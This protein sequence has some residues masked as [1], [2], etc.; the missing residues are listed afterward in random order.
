MFAKRTT[1]QSD[2]YVLL[3]IVATLVAIGLIFVYSSSSVYASEQFGSAHYYL[4]KHSIGILVG[5]FAF[6]IAKFISLQFLYTYAPLLF[7]GSFLLTLATLIPK[8]GVTIHG[9]SRWLSLPGL[10]FQPSEILKVAF[11]LYVARLL[12]K[13][14]GKTFTFKKSYLPILTIMALTAAVLLKQPDFGLTITLCITALAMV[15]ISGLPLTYLAVTCI[16]FLPAGI[17][18]IYMFPYRLARIM[19]FLNPWNDPQGAGFQIIQSLIAIGSGSWIGSGIA[20]SKQKFFYLPMQ[21]T[22][23]IFSII[24]E[25][26]G[27]IGISIIILLYILFLYKGM[28]IAWQLRTPFALNMVLGCTILITLQTIINIFVAT[29]L[30]PTKGIGLPMISYGNTSLVCTL[31]MIGLIANA[32]DHGK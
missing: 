27:F 11:I 21:H 9:S 20:H 28:K 23:F 3:G 12:S 4:K 31:L 17:L 32:V 13:Q 30:F 24:A 1:L 15:F 6:Y 22:D 29:G 25:E 16:A 5:I 8:I 18:L 19:T 26:T 14:H 7:A 2:W 10:L